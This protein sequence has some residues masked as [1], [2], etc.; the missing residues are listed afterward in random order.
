MSNQMKNKE[1]KTK[2]KKFSFA[3][4]LKI[5]AIVAVVGF[6]YVFYFL[7]HVKYEVDVEFL[8]VTK[9]SFTYKISGNQTI[10]DIEPE[11]IEGYEFVA[12]YKD[13]GM[14]QKYSSTDKVKRNSKIYL[15]YSPIIY[16]VFI[17]SGVGY[18]IEGT[19]TI[20]YNRNYKFEVI[21][22]DK[23]SN[24]NIEVRVN[25][26]IVTKNAEG[27]YVVQKVKKDLFISVSNV[28]VNDYSI[29]LPMGEGFEIT[30][31]STYVK[32]GEDFEF[33]VN[34]LNGYSN[35]IIQVKANNE[36]L[37]EVDGKYKVENVTSDVNIEVLGVQLNDLL[38]TLNVEGSTINLPVNNENDLLADVIFNTNNIDELEQF[39]MSAQKVANP[40]AMETYETELENVKSNMDKFDYLKLLTYSLTTGLI[41]SDEECSLGKTFDVKFNEF[42]DRHLNF[43]LKLTT[44]DKLDY[45]ASGT[46]MYVSQKDGSVSGEVV[47]PSMWVKDNVILN[48]TI[49]YYVKS[50][51]FKD[52]A[53]I[54]SVDIPLTVTNVSSSA[55]ENCTNLT[56]VYHYLPS[57]LDFVCG[58]YASS[59]FKNCKN[60]VDFEIPFG[61]QTIES[62]AFEKCLG[63][64]S[65]E[66]PI[67]VQTI[68][69]AVFLG[70]ENITSA[71]I[72]AKITKLSESMFQDCTS[73]I[74]VKY[75][76]NVKELG[77]S[78]FENCESLTDI[79]LTDNIETI[80]GSAFQG[81]IGLTNVVMSNKVSHLGNWAFRDCVNLQS[82]TL[83]DNVT[84]IGNRT[85]YNC[86]NLTNIT[87]P[88][89]VTIIDDY[90]FY[91]CTGLT[92]ITL[93]NGLQKLGEYV[94]K[95]CVS[96]QE[97]TI[98]AQVAIIDNYAFSGCTSLTSVTFGSGLQTLGI[99]AFERCVG[100]QEISIPAQV[101]TIEDFAFKQCV[102]LKCVTFEDNCKLTTIKEGVFVD[103][104]KLRK[105]ELPSNVRIL[106][107][108]CFGEGLESLT[109]PE[110]VTSIAARTFVYCPHLAEIYDLR[111]TQMKAGDY[112]SPSD[113]RI[114][115]EGENSVIYSDDSGLS[116]FESEQG[117]YKVIKYSGTAS[118]ITIPSTLNG[119]EIIEI[120]ECAFKNNKTITKVTINSE[121][122]VIGNSAFYKCQNLKTVEFEQ[123]NLLL[124][125]GDEAFWGCVNLINIAIPD[126]VQSI[127]G[128]AFRECEKIKSVVI[129]NNLTYMGIYA[130][131]HCLGLTSLVINPNSTNINYY[132]FT[133]C[134][135][136]LEI[137]DLRSIK[138]DP[139]DYGT[140]EDAVIL[141]ATDSSIY[142]VDANGFVF[143]QH[144]NNN[145]KLVDYV[146]DSK[147]III[148]SLFYN[149]AVVTEIREYA[150]VGKDIEK[151]V[152]S[153]TITKIGEF[154]FG[155]NDTLLNVEFKDTTGWQVSNSDTIEWTDV[156]ISPTD[157]DSNAEVCNT[158]NNLMWQKVQN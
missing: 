153:E 24:S 58:G 13:E 158:Y 89:N 129:P 150:F 104:F 147:D 93:G 156:T 59:A 74:S 16:D 98:P 32:H 143:I 14:S 132:A 124:E 34:L 64:T 52:N 121:T 103:C 120:R 102:N 63:L 21:L 78:V 137:R 18:K 130:F 110:T 70:C 4:F 107:W 87:I 67:S 75:S 46:T 45:E 141:G 66:I 3:K 92:N 8:G 1:E 114:L 122:S 116:Y 96:L 133:G 17:P 39:L 125:I 12:F 155:Y 100:L 138:M 109:I 140:P 111:T 51:A 80:G 136:L 91:G 40:I 99:S 44:P 105:L 123:G 30:P 48:G 157:F 2:S 50:N 112:C 9:E 61:I 26:N 27:K 57:E 108:E 19:K 37:T 60:L 117:K 56:R 15:K 135:K 85:F 22:D 69:N 101:S 82:I 146:G 79:P 76:S 5:I 90:T 152:I 29:T 119:S 43:Y 25:N 127:G 47:I 55:F 106:E 131:Q 33:A 128:Y 118:E 31:T 35:S 62:N 73:L 10:G 97:I 6:P 94:F 41:Y 154:A 68:G 81:C 83:S 88:N 142:Y 54:T 144:D 115:K 77:L 86:E 134:D 65:V 72:K 95:G 23:Y 149:G 71:N 11:E 84:G 126:T 7:N 20:S 151:V 148:P 28:L 42:K 38:L 113:V 139:G 53:N 49:N 36:L 145:Y